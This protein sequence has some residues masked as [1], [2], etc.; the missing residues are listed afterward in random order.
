M[1]TLGQRHVRVYEQMKSS[2]ASL[3]AYWQ[4]LTY[5]AL[6]RKAYITKDKNVGDRQPVDIYDS[7][8]IVSLAY[9]AAGMQAYMSGPQTKRFS[10]TLRNQRIMAGS[11][12]IRDYLKDTEDELYHLIN[13]SNF[14]QEDVE[15]YLN[16]G[17]VGTD[18]LYAEEDIKDG[19]RFDSV[20]IE[21]IC[22]GA[23]ASGRINKAYMEYEFNC[24]QAI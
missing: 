14:Y 7:T 16:L 19:M 11:K 12:E 10:L 20:P 8:A 3:E 23:D 22:I 13:N 24:E 6:P 2:R 21:N 15:S 17:S 4:D 18:V 1:E 9:F 5:F